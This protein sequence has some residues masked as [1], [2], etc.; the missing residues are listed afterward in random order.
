VELIYSQGGTICGTSAGMHILSSFV[1][2]AEDGTVYPYECIENPNNHY[3]T[4]EN[5]FFDFAPGYLF[6]THFAERGR[7]G[8]LCGFLAN[9]ELNK[10]LKVIGI[11]IDD[12]TCMTVDTNHLGTVYGT[13]CANIYKINGTSSLNG[14]KLLADSIQVFQLLQG[15]TYHF[16]TEETT[17]QSL[18]REIITDAQSETGNY[19][20][21]AS[22]SKMLNDNLGMLNDLALITGYQH[23][24]VL[25]LS[26][27]SSL[28]ETF[29]NKLIQMGV[30]V[31]GVVVPT[32]SFGTD[33]AF[34][35]KVARA[36]KYLFLDNPASS[37]MQFMATP[38]GI[39]LKNKIK[40][41]GS[42][43]AFAG[44]DARFAGKTIVD[45]YLEYGNSYYAEMTF[46]KGIGLLKNTVILP[47]TYLNSDIY[48]N[49]A[50]AVPY[51]M[52]ADTLRYGIW[53]TNHNYMK[54]APVEGKAVLTGYGQAPVMVVK[55]TGH[56]AGFS[57][58]TSTG[59]SGMDP[60][61][62][63][64]FERL[65]LALI[66]N[67]RPFIMGDIQAQAIQQPDGRMPFSIS[68]DKLHGTIQLNT[69]CSQGSWN[70]IAM[71]GRIT[72]KGFITGPVTIVD[73]SSMHR[74]VYI[75]EV[76]EDRMHKS[77]SLKFIW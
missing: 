56:H 22:G 28:A 54:Y 46:S 76:K 36:A 32:L 71:D 29:R 30:T 23:D 66:D 4:I 35:G 60:R 37:F 15:C 49:T 50:T 39:A 75:M 44:D 69:W 6:D 9:L 25:I 16:L 1:Y 58:Q 64:G 13:G 3:V 8:R 74:G 47:N 51:A 61:Q 63:A 48:E 42:I 27:N 45:N 11:G 21:L 53:L 34:A 40:S 12:L 72:R 24:P 38:N 7:F 20:L 19:T 77:N 65:E 55:N 68:I 17:I 70:I 10:G 31:E 5:D 26:G 73:I 67:T 18:D 57:T 59:S 62:V 14:T 41:D 33:T 43:S 52:A 2:T